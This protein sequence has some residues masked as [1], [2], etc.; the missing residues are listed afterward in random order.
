MW[1]GEQ[2]DNFDIYVKLIGVGEPLRLTTSPKRDM[3][4]AWS[5]DGRYIAFLRGNGEGKGFYL[6]PALGGAERKLTDAYGWE[7]RGVMNQAVAWSPDGRR[8]AVVDKAGEDEPWC[9]FLL[10]STGERRK[11]TAPPA[12]TDGETTVA[13]SPDGRTL[14]FVRSH[15]LVGDIYL[16]PGDIYLAPVAGGDPVRLTFDEATIDALAWT[17][18]GAAL[19]FSSE[20]G[21]A[22]RP[23]LWRVPAAGGTPAHLGLS[24]GVYDLSISRQGNLLAFAQESDD[25]D[26]YRVELMAQTGGRRKA[27]TPINLITSTRSDSDPQFSRRAAGRLHLESFWQIQSVGMRRGWQELGA[28]DR[29]PLPGYAEV[30]AGRA[31]YRL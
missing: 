7:R 10:S 15:N 5:P 2:H 3:S 8:L 18:D 31:A 11:F 28:V 12:K 30:V 26:I 1:T 4:P 22:S 9:I 24:D 23:T 27:G 16:A 14:A 29:R 13:F 19:V 25:F 6:V 21:D 17:P 20:H